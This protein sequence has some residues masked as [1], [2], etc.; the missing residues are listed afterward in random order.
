MFSGDYATAFPRPPIPWGAP[1]GGGGTGERG[2]IEITSN[3]SKELCKGGRGAR[4]GI[5]FGSVSFE[6]G[7]GK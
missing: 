6:V 4:G 7:E 3:S 1:G 5:G 2:T